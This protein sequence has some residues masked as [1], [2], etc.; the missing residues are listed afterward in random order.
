MTNYYFLATAVPPLQI[1]TT[2]DFSFEDLL[3]AYRLNLTAEDMEG[4]RVI[5]SYYDIENIRCFWMHEPLDKHGNLDEVQLE[6]AIITG[7]GLPNYVK[8]YLEKWEDLGNRLKHFPSLFTAFFIEEQKTAKGF[9]RFFLKMER[10]LRLVMT[11]FRAKK[12][13][14]DFAKELQYE[15]IPELDLLWG[16][17]L[18]SQILAQ[19]DAP[20]FEPPEKYQ[21]LKPIFERFHNSP[22]ELYKALSEWR[23]N[24][25]EEILGFDIFS[26]DR[27][28]GYFLQ[29]IIVEKWLELDRKKGLEIVH[30]ILKD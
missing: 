2:P 14:R 26:S 3:L 18:V 25:I 13:G 8:D 9:V 29:F 23:F 1:G 15:E 10:E 27:V 12:L 11:G 4:I 5:R 24:K 16:E 7:D 20:S 22:L 28:L 6:E 30:S 17:N 21:S 19:K